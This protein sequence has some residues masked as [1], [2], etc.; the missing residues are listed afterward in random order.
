[1]PVCLQDY[2]KPSRVRGLILRFQ[3]LVLL[4]HKVGAVFQLDFV[5]TVRTLAVA[6]VVHIA[7][8]L[9]L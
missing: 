6:F 5:I 3:L 2:N 7:V 8:A 9:L 1:M 4:K